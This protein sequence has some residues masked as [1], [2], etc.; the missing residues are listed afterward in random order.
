[1]IWLSDNTKSLIVQTSIEL[2]NES[3]FENVS[4]RDIASYLKMSPG[5]LTYHFKKKTD[6]LYAIVQ[7]LVEEHQNHHY[8]SYV[9][10]ADFNATLLNIINH[11]KKYVFYYRSITELRR[12]YPS[13]TRLQMDYKMEFYKLLSDIFSHF[14]ESGW[15]KQEFRQCQY[16]DLAVAVLAVTTFWAQLNFEEESWNMSAVVWSVILPNLTEKGMLE[17]NK[18]SHSGALLL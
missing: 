11:Q 14:E 8:S 13:I 4:M 7:L 17:Y 18:F 16:N 15:M 1:M 6:I 10:L 9:T 2:F 12:K 5:N 3:G